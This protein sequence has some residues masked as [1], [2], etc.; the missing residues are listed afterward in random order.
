M[1]EGRVGVGGADVTGGT[2]YFADI[3]RQ[4]PAVSVPCAVF[5]D[6]KGAGGDGLSGVPCDKP[7]TRM[8]GAGE[9]AGGNLEIAAVDVALVESDITVVDYFPCGVAP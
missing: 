3:L 5:A 9:V 6:G 2:E 7:Q 8:A 1:P 4:I